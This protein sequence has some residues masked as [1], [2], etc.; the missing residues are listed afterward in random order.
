[1]EKQR[2][3]SILSTILEDLATVE[4]ER[5]ARW[6]K[7]MHSKGERQADGGL[8][9]P[10]NLAAQW[11]RKMAASYAELTEPEKESDREQVRKYLPIIAEAFSRSEIG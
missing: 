1:M 3:E 6:Q 11:D 7:Y 4:H 10:A 2:V 9:I 8:V 5:W